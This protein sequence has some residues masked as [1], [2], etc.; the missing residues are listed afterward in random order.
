MRAS[1][2]MICNMVEAL[3]HGLIKANMKAIMPLAENMAL[4]GICGMM[5]ANT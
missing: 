2:K 3:K 4:V 1:G 5:A